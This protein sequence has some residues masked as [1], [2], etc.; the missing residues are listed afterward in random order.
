MVGNDFLEEMTKL[1]F[2]VSI[3]SENN[4]VVSKGDKKL[5][6]TLE[7]VRRIFMNSLVSHLDNN[8]N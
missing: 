6:L 5:I 1:G 7:K 2:D 4:I 3:E 8:W